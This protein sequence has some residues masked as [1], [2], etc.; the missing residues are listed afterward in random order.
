MP[1]TLGRSAPFGGG[2]GLSR[3]SR[4]IET[5]KVAASTVYAAANPTWVTS[6]P[7]RAGPAIAPICHRVPWMAF[8]AGISCRFISRGMSAFNDGRCRPSRAAI[9]P[10]P[11]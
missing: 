6:S 7:P 2:T 9:P 11:R 5:A 3:I 8:A 4:T 10:A 1:A